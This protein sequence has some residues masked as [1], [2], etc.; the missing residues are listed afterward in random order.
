IPAAPRRCPLPNRQPSP[1]IPTDPPASPIPIQPMHRRLT[2]S[3]ALGALFVARAASAQ[4]VTIGYSGLPYKYQGDSQ[5]SGIQVSDGVLMHV[6]A[7]AEAGY[8]SNVFY[9]DP[10]SGI[11]GSGLLRVTTY[12]ELT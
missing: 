3:I 11:V 1:Y 12:A 7:G 6:G 5:N 4:E 10:G 2:L 8:D 9:A